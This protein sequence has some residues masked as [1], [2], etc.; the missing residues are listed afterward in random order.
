MSQN[1]LAVIEKI[2]V[3]GGEQ[4]GEHAWRNPIRKDTGPILQALVMA[5][6]PKNILELGTGYGLSTCYLALGDSQSKIHT[7][8]F[9]R[10]VA[11]QATKHFQ[12]AGI[13]HR[14]R[15]WVC[16]SAEA[17]E[18][19][20]AQIP[21]PDFVFVD[22]SKPPY[23]DDVEAI[24][25]RSEGQEFLLVADNVVDRQQELKDFLDWMPSIALN[26]TVISTQCGLLVA[27][28]KAEK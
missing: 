26:L 10:A 20:P 9:D 12:D 19:I 8:E 1:V 17:I 28:V 27:R 22:H 18:Q 11:E 13:S 2:C 6:R 5:A 7:V 24:A 14:I 3:L 21:I 23:K 16:G 4:Y 25:S 15:Q